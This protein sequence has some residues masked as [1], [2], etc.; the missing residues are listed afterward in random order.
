MTKRYTNKDKRQIKEWFNAGLS[1]LDIAKELGRTPD[2]IQQYRS[3][4]G[5]VRFRRA[6]NGKRIK[7]A[8]VDLSNQVSEANKILATFGMK[9]DVVRA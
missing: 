1:D 9:I 2:A 7:P 6:K 3:S 5:I 8:T 4:Q